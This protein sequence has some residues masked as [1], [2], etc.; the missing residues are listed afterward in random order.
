MFK[1]LKTP[2]IFLSTLL[3]VLSLNYYINNYKE[4]KYNDYTCIELVI[5]NN[6]FTFWVT[7][8]NEK[9]ESYRL[10]WY[11]DTIDGVYKNRLFIVDKDYLDN[12]INVNKI[13]CPKQLLKESMILKKETSD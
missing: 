7:Q 1:T 13:I 2:L 8:Y 5:K 6:I 10:V 9:L 3:L 4:R 11:N 12:D